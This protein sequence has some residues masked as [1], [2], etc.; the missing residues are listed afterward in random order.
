MNVEH[1]IGWCANMGRDKT[2]SGGVRRCS[3][4]L[5]EEISDPENFLRD[6]ALSTPILLPHLLAVSQLFKQ[7]AEVFSTFF[8]ASLTLF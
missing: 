3:I 6:F 1:A 7:T 8:A 5:F 4:N 2:F